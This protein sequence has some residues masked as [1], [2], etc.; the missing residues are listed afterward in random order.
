MSSNDLAARQRIS[1]F[2]TGMGFRLY[3]GRE[4]RWYCQGCNKG[5]WMTPP[6]HLVACSNCCGWKKPETT[7]A[8]R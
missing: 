8:K 2:F 6:K 1:E 4:A 5:S 7:E 3:A